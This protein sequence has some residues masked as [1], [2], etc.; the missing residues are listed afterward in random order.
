MLN[1]QKE[2]KGDQLV[3]SLSG[4]IGEDI[5]FEELIG[6]VALKKVIVN[7]RDVDSINSAGIKE[8]INY[9]R[10]LKEKGIELEFEESSCPVTEQFSLISNFDCKGKVTSVFAPFACTECNHIQRNLFTIDKLKELNFEIPPQKCEKCGKESAEFDE[11][12]E[13]YFNH[14]TD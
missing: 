14:F 7:T 12:P 4:K 1:A 3:I 10:G 9:F 8:W 11:I 2:Q 13:E 5:R 6:E